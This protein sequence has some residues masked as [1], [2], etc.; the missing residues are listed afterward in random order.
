M[1]FFGQRDMLRIA[2]KTDASV[3][4]AGN[5]DPATR[6]I[7]MALCCNDRLTANSPSTIHNSTLSI[8]NTVEVSLRSLSCHRAD[9]EFFFARAWGNLRM[10]PHGYMQ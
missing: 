7:C 8:N 10:N 3:T 5:F 1:D 4:V 2:S 6:Q 9:N